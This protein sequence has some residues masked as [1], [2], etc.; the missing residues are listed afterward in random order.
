MEDFWTFFSF[1]LNLLLAV[2]W[3]IV[4]R[5][6]WKHHRDNVAVR[7]LLSPAATV[8][9]LTMLL[10]SCL[11]IGLSGSRDFVQ[12]IVFVAVLLY[13]QTVLLLIIFRGWRRSDGKVRWRFLLIHV[14][15]LL[16]VGSGFWGSPDSSDVRVRLGRGESARE[17]YSLDGHRVALSYELSMNDYEAEYSDDGQPSYFE[18]SVSIDGG[19]P[20]FIT[21]NHPYGVRLGEDIYLVSVSDTGCVFQIVREIWKYFALAGIIMLIVGAFMLFIKGPGR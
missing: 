6:G 8:S 3:V 4:L 2:L 13:L 18:A 16:A 15:L 10:A 12:S 20:V 1:P 5:W 9:A 11:W 7:F 21:V 17:A 19:E 14:G